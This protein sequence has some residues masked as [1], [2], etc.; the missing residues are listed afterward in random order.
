MRKGFPAGLSLF[1]KPEVLLQLLRCC[2][3]TH[4]NAK[5][6]SREGAAV[7][8]QRGLG[9]APDGWLQNGGGGLGSKCKG[10]HIRTRD[11]HFTFT[12]MGSVAD[13]G[14]DLGVLVDFSVKVCASGEKGPFHA[15][16]N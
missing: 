3:I 13:Q 1:Q 5:P 7:C 16:G 10:R 11:P 14:R 15:G 6:T 9:R 2:Q 12:L 4:N 8:A